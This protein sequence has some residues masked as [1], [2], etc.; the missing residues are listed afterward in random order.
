MIRRIFTIT[1]ILVGCLCSYAQVTYNVIARFDDDDSGSMAYIV[2]FDSSEVIDS[3]FIDNGVANFK[4]SVAAPVMAVLNLEDEELLRFILEG[5]DTEITVKEELQNFKGGVLNSK[6][7]DLGQKADSL[8]AAYRMLPDNA[9][10]EQRD[11][12]TNGYVSLMLNALDENI[13]NPIGYIILLS[14]AE[15]MESEDIEEYIGENQLLK[16]SI[17]LNNIIRF[18]KNAKETSEGM[19]FK[20]FTTVYNGETFTLSDH[21]GKGKY[22]LVDFWASWC[23]PCQMQ[24]PVLKEIHEKYHEC[25][26]EVISIAVWDEPENTLEAIKLHNM[27]WKQ[28]IDAQSIPTDV[29]GISGI[30]CIILFDKD[31]TILSRGKQGDEL[32]AAVDA[33]LCR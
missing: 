2:D 3:A 7:E 4:G 18:K 6:L 11:S 30:P 33:A 23:Y 13:D 32:K 22:V 17:R 5:G 9:S 24:I 16:K 19:P 12:V 14:M 25:G 1:V 29:Y 27:P 10:S 21:V 8:I 26:L 15:N 31:G 28:V 20:D